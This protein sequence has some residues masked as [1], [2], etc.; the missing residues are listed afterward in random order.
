[1]RN[2]IKAIAIERT[3]RGAVV[4]QTSLN[5]LLANLGTDAIL[6]GKKK[7]VSCGDCIKICPGQTLEIR[8]VGSTPT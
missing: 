7:Y 5:R 1:M 3:T 6:A 8:Q 4:I 2:L